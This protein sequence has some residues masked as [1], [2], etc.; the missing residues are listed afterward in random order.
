MAFNQK[1]VFSSK[2]ISWTIVSIVILGVF[3]VVLFNM[4][5]KPSD[6]ANASNQSSSSQSTP[7]PK[8]NSDNKNINSSTMSSAPINSQLN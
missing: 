2:V 1:I 3:G 6:T 8:S 4:F 7:L 5:L